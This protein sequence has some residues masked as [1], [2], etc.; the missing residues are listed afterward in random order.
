MKS[1][2]T[3]LC[4]EKKTVYEINMNIIIPTANKRYTAWEV[5]NKVQS[6]ECTDSK[7]RKWL[8]RVAAV[9]LFAL[10]INEVLS[11]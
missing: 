8:L 2:D 10:A 7:S 11:L 4:K 6:C 5:S 3:Y 1:I 9:V